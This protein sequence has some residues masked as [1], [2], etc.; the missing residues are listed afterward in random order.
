MTMSFKITKITTPDITVIFSNTGFQDST[1]TIGGLPLNDKTALVQALT[2][3][4]NAY[5]SGLA[6]VT[7]KVAV[8]KE[9]SDAVGQ[10]IQAN[11]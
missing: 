10:S 2:D 4:G 3:Y 11:N 1:Q 8:A 7:A 6:Q 9:I 5:F